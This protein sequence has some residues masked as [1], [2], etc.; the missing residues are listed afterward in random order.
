MATLVQT[1]TE[2][3]HKQRLHLLCRV[4]GNRSNKSTKPRLPSLCKYVGSELKKIHQIDI[5]LDSNDTHSSTLCVKC[6]ARLVKIKSGQTTSAVTIQNAK[7][8]TEK[9]VYLWTGFNSLLSVE[10][11][12]AC[13]VFEIQKKGGRPA[14][15]KKVSQKPDYVLTACNTTVSD[16]DNGSRIDQ[17]G[18][19]MSPFSPAGTSTPM[20]NVSFPHQS[21]VPTS[22]ASSLRLTPD[23]TQMCF[24][25]TTPNKTPQ[26]MEISDCATFP[27][28]KTPETKQAVDCATSPHM[29]TPETKQTV[30][31]ATSPFESQKIQLRS[32]SS[33][34][35][36]LSR[37]EEAY[38]TQLTRI[39][40]SESDDKSTVRCKTRGQPIVMK[41]VSV[42]RKSSSLAASPLRKKRAKLIEKIR[43][44]VSG[45]SQEDVVKQQGTELKKTTKTHRQ[46]VL[47]VA[48]IKQPFI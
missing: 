2:L 17:D 29:K 22:T 10:D 1:H 3:L 28:M 34:S 48:G 24:Q 16:S 6:Y 15:Q 13:S 9:A 23:K 8:D 12:P 18:S 31:C 35:F 47:N 33:L 45:Q 14:K 43:L 11:C 39:K 32:I 25:T 42:P 20:K 30:D 21:D 36:P 27:H 41:K 5:S 37:E 38:H 40:L 7:L 46:N 26:T 44:D 19:A 4:C